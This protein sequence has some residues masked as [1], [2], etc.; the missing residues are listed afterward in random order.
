[1]EGPSATLHPW[2]QLPGP[3]AGPEDKVE[4]HLPPGS[5]DAWHR[6]IWAS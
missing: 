6:W 4:G 5:M 1:M 2:E 3:E